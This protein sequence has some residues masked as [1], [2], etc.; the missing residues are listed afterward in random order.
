MAVAGHNIIDVMR[1]C[2]VAKAPAKCALLCTKAEKCRKMHCV[3]KVCADATCKVHHPD[4][5]RPADVE[6]QRMQERKRIEAQKVEITVRHQIF[7]QVLQK[8]PSPFGKAE[9]EL[10]AMRLLDRLD[11]QRRVLIAKRP[12]LIS[13]KGAESDRNEMV[14]GFKKMFRESDDKAIC[15]LILECLLIDSAYHIPTGG[16]DLLLATAKRYRIDAEK[17]TRHVRDDLAA[18]AKK[19]AAK[20]AGNAAA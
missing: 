16:D 13:G 10:I 1:I 9:L 8:V 2:L 7:A 15:R 11:Y 6:K 4:A 14:S 17:V 19:K 18:K 5:S 20:K 3:G 12:K